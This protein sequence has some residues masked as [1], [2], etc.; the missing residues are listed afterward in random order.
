MKI[1]KEKLAIERARQSLISSGKRCMKLTN[2]DRKTQDF[3]D[4]KVGHASEIVKIYFF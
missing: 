2:V 4:S 1:K 3:V